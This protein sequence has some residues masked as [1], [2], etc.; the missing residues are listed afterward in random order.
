MLRQVNED[1]R[2]E[3]P[4]GLFGTCL[5]HPAAGKPCADGDENRDELA[6]DERWDADQQSH[7]GAGIRPGDQPREKGPLKRQVR[8]VVVEEDPGDHARRQRQAD[9]QGENQAVGPSAPLEDEDV[10][11]LPETSKHRGQHRHEGKL[12]DEGRQQELVGGEEPRL[13]E[14]RGIV[15]SWAS[16]D[17]TLP[18][19]ALHDLP[20]HVQEVGDGELPGP[21]GPDVPE[22]PRQA[23]A[24][25]GRERPGEVRR[26]RSVFGGVPCRRHI[27]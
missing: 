4:N 15:L 1:Q 14:H 21:E 9:G 22:V 23:G 3:L 24:D 20:A 10:P 5:A 17:W 8:C 13:F 27:P 2:C 19:G 25:A 16:H 18:H 7:R 11:E 6:S 12:D 26:L